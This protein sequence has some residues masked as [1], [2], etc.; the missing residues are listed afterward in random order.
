MLA[1]A[2][3]F[4]TG[5]MFFVALVLACLYRYVQVERKG[6][7]REVTCCRLCFLASSSLL[8]PSLPSCL[9]SL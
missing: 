4:E 3:L 8:L 2:K 7:R 1:A 5:L 6:K 9:T